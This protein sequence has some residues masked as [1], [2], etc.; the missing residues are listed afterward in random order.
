MLR[1][2][3]AL[4]LRL[5]KEAGADE[6]AMISRLYELT[7]ARK[8]RLDELRLTQNFLRGQARLFVT[9]SPRRNGVEAARFAEGRDVGDGGGVG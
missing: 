2:G 8:P 3:R 6:R 7:L 9:A 1:Q 4:A 5:F